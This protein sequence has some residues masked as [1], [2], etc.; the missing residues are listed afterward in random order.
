MSEFV[1]MQPVTVTISKTDYDR[2]LVEAT[3]TKK[4][5]RSALTVLVALLRK[6]ADRASCE[7]ADF[8]ESRME[9]LCDGL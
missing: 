9:Q 2:L 1:H 6:R 7:V 5:L 3:G 4:K 8:I